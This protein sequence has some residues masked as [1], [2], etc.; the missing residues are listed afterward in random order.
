MQ[1]KGIRAA[2]A[3]RSDRSAGAPEKFNLYMKEECNYG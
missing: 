2:G 3:E 1:N